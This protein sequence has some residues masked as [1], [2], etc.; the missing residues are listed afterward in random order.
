LPEL[1]MPISLHRAADQ[2]AGAPLFFLVG[3]R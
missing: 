1:A 2:N 3:N